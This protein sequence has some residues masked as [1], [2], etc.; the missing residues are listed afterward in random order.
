MNPSEL[1]AALM[2][3]AIVLRRQGCQNLATSVEE[4]RKRLTP[5]VNTADR[6]RK[7]LTVVV[8][9]ARQCSDDKCL[10]GVSLAWLEEVTKLVIASHQPPAR[11]VMAS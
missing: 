9:N 1:D 8:L 3:A 6:M 4:A 7:A 10:V 5:D 11:V 2:N